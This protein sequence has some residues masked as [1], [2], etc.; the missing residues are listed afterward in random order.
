M[1]YSAK[2]FGYIDEK[3]FIKIKNNCTGLSVQ[4]YNLI[5]YLKEKNKK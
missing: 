2:K 5:K 3:D 1:L 4:I